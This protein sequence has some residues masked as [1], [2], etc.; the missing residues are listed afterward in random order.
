MRSLQ[1]TSR[2]SN[3]A[4]RGRHKASLNTPLY[5]TLIFNINRVVVLRP[6]CHK[7]GHFEDVPHG[8]I[9]PNTTKAHI[10]QAKEMYNTK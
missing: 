8:K 7:I 6:A 4:E 10:H 1:I 2:S 3:R 5:T 9:K